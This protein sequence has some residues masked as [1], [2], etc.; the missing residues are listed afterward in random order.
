VLA[1]DAETVAGPW[2]TDPTPPVAAAPEAGV[3]VAAVLLLVAE[4][5]DVTMGIIVLVLATGVVVGGSDTMFAL[6][7][8]CCCCCCCCC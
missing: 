8:S 1:A 7:E 5:E 6:A 2:E 4:F 3:G